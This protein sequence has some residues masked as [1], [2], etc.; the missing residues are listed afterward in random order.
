[1]FL[2]S[3]QI[4]L[5]NQNAIFLVFFPF[6]VRLFKITPQKEFKKQKMMVM[7]LLCTVQYEYFLVCDSLFL[8]CNVYT[9]QYMYCTLN[10]I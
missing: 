7:W 10:Y 5:I 9:A 2:L 4:A 8:P 1:M 6:R 3:F